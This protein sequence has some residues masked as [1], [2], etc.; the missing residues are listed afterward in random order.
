M[1]TMVLLAVRII[2]KCTLLTH[3]WV[4]S[5]MSQTLSDNMHS[6]LHIVT[7]LAFVDLGTTRGPLTD[8]IFGSKGVF[9]ELTDNIV[10]VSHENE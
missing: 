6:R 9:S 5:L 7:R 4:S 10:R 1:H 8:P 2:I 3:Q